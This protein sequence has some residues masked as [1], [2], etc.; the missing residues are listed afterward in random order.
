MRSLSRF[1]VMTLST[2]MI[3]LIS[4]TAS[5]S[6]YADQSYDKY[7][8]SDKSERY[9][10]RD[11]GQKRKPSHKAERYPGRYRDP[12]HRRPH[13]RPHGSNRPHVIHHGPPHRHRPNRIRR[14]HNVIIV[15]PHGH[16]YHGYGWH[17]RD[18]DAFKWLAFTAITLKILDNLNEGQQRAHEAAQ[19]RATEADVGETVYWNRD[20]ASG[21]VTVLRDG[22]STTGRYCR[23]FQQE[24]T[25][26]G[27]GEAAYGTACR[28][29]DGSWEVISTGSP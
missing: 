7:K 6:L 1:L 17:R 21:S 29:P 26:A 16:W 9:R 22:T 12:K 27:K 14:H 25:I 3:G 20:G 24:V 28:N 2:G 19:I 4:F 8:R 11:R 23:E 13:Q 5:T 18:N 10:D 15:R